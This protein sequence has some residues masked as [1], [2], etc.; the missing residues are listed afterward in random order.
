MLF[1]CNLS[2]FK[3]VA[4]YCVEGTELGI[5]QLFEYWLVIEFYNL[6]WAMVDKHPLGWYKEDR[7]ELLAAPSVSD[8]NWH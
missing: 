6:E 5:T 8:T 2:E 7:E 4:D 3:R 1:V